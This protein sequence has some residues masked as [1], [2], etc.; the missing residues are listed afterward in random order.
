MPS[1]NPRLSV[2][3]T[4]SLAA[5]LAALSKETGD[6]ASGLVRG[7]LEQSE[8][9][10]LRM[11]EL[12]KSAKAAKGQIGG[13]LASTVHRVV[14]DLQDALAL[15]EIRIARVSGDLVSQAQA[16]KGRRRAVESVSAKSRLAAGRAARAT[17]GQAERE[18]PVTPPEIPTTGKKK[19]RR[20]VST[21][22]PVTRGSGP[23]KTLRKPAAK[24][25]GRGRV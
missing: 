25:T 8:P 6:S 21:P 23:G 12:V 22:V 11:L 4:P 1:A 15:A 3:L 16:I 17:S 14:D 2:V 18:V 19:R 10:L 24:G 5:T 20:A 7:F 13:G 9:A